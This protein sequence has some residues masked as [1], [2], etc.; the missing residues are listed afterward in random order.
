MKKSTIPNK[1]LFYNSSIL[2]NV[3]GLSMRPLASRAQPPL[4]YAKSIEGAGYET[5]TSIKDR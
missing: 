3:T 1:I 2:Y 5:S 4:N